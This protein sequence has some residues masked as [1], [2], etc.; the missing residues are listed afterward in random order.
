MN[1]R[2]GVRKASS[3]STRLTKPPL[4]RSSYPPSDIHT[5]Q[6]LHP[7]PASFSPAAK[8]T[9]SSLSKPQSRRTPL[10][11]FT[12]RQTFQFALIRIALLRTRP[13]ATCMSRGRRAYTCKQSKAV[14]SLVAGL[15]SEKEKGQGK[16]KGKKNRMRVRNGYGLLPAKRTGA[17]LFFV[18]HL[19]CG[20]PLTGEIKNIKATDTTA[21][22]PTY[23]P[24]LRFVAL[25]VLC[26]QS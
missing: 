14:T 8:K 19:L 18:L 12:R 23:F 16:G 24:W 10:E 5:S 21:V 26:K 22:A 17:P 6:S 11:N 7:R 15:T 2:S 3:S 20:C 1:D 25:R 4:L 13:L 9:L